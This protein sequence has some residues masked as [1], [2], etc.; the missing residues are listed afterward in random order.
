MGVNLH[1]I[2][3]VVGGSKYFRTKLQGRLKVTSL[4]YSRSHN[5]PH[6]SVNS[7]ESS[8]KALLAAQPLQIRSRHRKLLMIERV[9]KVS[10]VVQD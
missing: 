5:T 3:P 10:F 7:P 4:E 1:F 2:L 6:K 9:K 8:V